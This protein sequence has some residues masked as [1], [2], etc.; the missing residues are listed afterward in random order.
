MNNSNDRTLIAVFDSAHVRFFE[1]KEAHSHLETVLGDVASGLHHDRRDIET[2]RPGRGFS[3][4][5]QHHAYESEHDPRKLE[6]HDF[7]Q[8]ISVA[9]EAALDQHAY[10]RLAIVAP[11]RSVG[12]FRS[13]AS[14]KVLRTMW[15]EVPKEMANLTDAQLREHLIPLLQHPVK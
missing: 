2:D 7:V 4:G 3:S 1:Y 12:E 6:K 11:S 5:G 14:E 15:K 8:A 10:T 13:V 9:I